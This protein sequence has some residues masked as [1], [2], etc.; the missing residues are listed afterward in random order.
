MLGAA[1]NRG[2][3]GPL[4]VSLAIG[5]ALNGIHGEQMSR[6]L[7]ACQARTREVDDGGFVD[8]PTGMSRDDA[9]DAFAEALIGNTHHQ[10][11]PNAVMRLQRFFDFFGKY[12]L[13]AGIDADRTT[14]QQDQ[15]AIGC[16]AGE[17]TWKRVS[18]PANRTKRPG[19]LFRVL[20]LA[21]RH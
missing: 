20:V 2:L 5:R 15:R 14:P 9:D 3:P 7:V 12:L 11:I 4:I 6:E 10:R 21:G 18:D 1:L 17:I 16:N 13:T 8:G 19:A